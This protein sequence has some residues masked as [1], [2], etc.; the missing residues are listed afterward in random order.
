[1]LGLAT[2]EWIVLL[3][4]FGVFLV[5]SIIATIIIVGRLR[6]PYNIVIAQ[7]LV[8]GKPEIIGRDKARLVGIGDGGEEIFFLK[9][10][11]KYKAG[12]GVRIGKNQILWVIGQDGYWYNCDFG[13]FN[14]SLLSVGLRPLDRNVRLA[15][16][17]MRKSIDN[18]YETKGF[19]DKYGTIINMGMMFLIIIAFAGVMWFAFSKQQEIAS[20]TAEGSKVNKETMQLNYETI[21]LLNSVLGNIDRIKETGS[22][23]GIIFNSTTTNG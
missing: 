6:W 5:V 14:R 4:L 23:S 16:A 1:M 18:R 2:W 17:S 13:D 20:S 21:Q 22:G 3:S 9:K 11:K 10:R 19:M 7:E 8:S 12:V 15:T